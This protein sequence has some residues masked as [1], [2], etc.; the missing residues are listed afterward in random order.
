MRRPYPFQGPVITFDD[1]M[2]RRYRPGLFWEETDAV[3][4]IV[5][6]DEYR[7]LIDTLEAARR[8]LTST[9]PKKGGRPPKWTTETLLGIVVVALV[10][11][12]DLKQARHKVYSHNEYR[13]LVGLPDRDEMQARPE[14]GTK[15]SSSVQDKA[16]PSEKTVGDFISRWLKDHEELF[17]ECIRGLTIDVAAVAVND[18]AL[19]T[20]WVAVDGTRVRGATEEPGG[21]GGDEGTQVFSREGEGS[22]NQRHH[23][24]AVLGSVPLI[25]HSEITEPIGESTYWRERGLPALRVAGEQLARS[26]DDL[27]LHRGEAAKPHPGLHRAA[28]AS[29]KALSGAPPAA[30]IIANNFIPAVLRTEDEVKEYGTVTGVRRGI[31]TGYTVRSDGGVMCPDCTEPDEVTT[32]EP[33][34]ILRGEFGISVRL[35]CGDPTCDWHGKTVSLVL[36]KRDE[37]GWL[38]GSTASRGDRDHSVISMLP[39]WSRE[40]A[41]RRFLATQRVEWTHAQMEQLFGLGDKN[42][43]FAR[44]TIKGAHT[45]RVWWALGALIWNLTLRNNLAT[46]GRITD[47]SRRVGQIAFNAQEN[48]DSI[49]EKKDHK[50]E[51]LAKRAAKEER[52]A[53]R[54]AAYYERLKPP[55]TTRRDAEPDPIETVAQTTPPAL[56]APGGANQ[57]TNDSD[58]RSIPR[59]TQ[60]GDAAEIIAPDVT[61]GMMPHPWS[62]ASMLLRGH[63]TAS[64]SMPTRVSSTAGST[65]PT[66]SMCLRRGEPEPIA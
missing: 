58:P 28:L 15:P 39:T 3:A 6:S 27:R 51:W 56:G 52:K 4:E 43:G 33:M 19:E 45:N 41:A 61:P 8:G 12:T 11:G 13:A 54:R 1:V 55:A 30:A 20:N 14:R 64:H 29:D 46:V 40:Y 31:P 16:F 37:N 10:L 7:T 57:R 60:P 65:A 18:H 42:T 9:G 23:Y 63:S 32:K 49:Q 38:P 24:V 66:R 48:H 25:V 5:H 44:R 26:I 62:S 22:F 59:T 21:P 2:S 47:A 50:K 17:F 53:K 36:R 35:R 34:Q